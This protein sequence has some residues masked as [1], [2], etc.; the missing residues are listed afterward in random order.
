MR[1]FFLSIVILSSMLFSDEG[2][3]FALISI[4]KSGTGLINKCI[5]QLTSKKRSYIPTLKKMKEIGNSQYIGTHF[6]HVK[7]VNKLTTLPHID[8][9]IINIRDPRDILI[10][11]AHFY[12]DFNV[13]DQTKPRDFT[14]LYSFGQLTIK[15]RIKRYLKE[16]LKA[17][18]IPTPIYDIKE[19]CEFIRN[20]QPQLLVIK[21]EDLVGEQGGGSKD[22][23]YQT[24]VKIAKFLEVNPDQVNI[25][26]ISDVIYGNSPTFRKGSL[27]KWKVVFDEEM[28]RMCK[29]L[30]GKELIELGYEKDYNW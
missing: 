25:G 6:V 3:D 12:P 27:G 21:Y 2:A 29:E 28:K 11:A 23:Q 19:A 14:P 26:R 7:V 15:Q 18:V 13:M 1:L 4:A 20:N 8:K 16:G 10:A 24:I 9:L 5:A 17:H 22:A 30:F